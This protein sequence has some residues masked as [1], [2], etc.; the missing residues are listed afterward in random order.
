MRLFV[1]PAALFLAFVLYCAAPKFADGLARA[2]QKL[3]A[4][5]QRPRASSPFRRSC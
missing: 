3:Y 1:Y 2:L 5:F 4:L